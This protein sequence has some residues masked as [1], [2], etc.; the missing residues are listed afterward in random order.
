[1]KNREREEVCILRISHEGQGGKTVRA[2]AWID[3]IASTR[4]GDPVT[5]VL[6]AKKRERET[7]SLR[8]EKEKTVLGHGVSDAMVHALLN[9]IQRF[10]HPTL[11]FPGGRISAQSQVI[12]VVPWI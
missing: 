4:Y 8:R 10:R 3:G 9:L 5:R 1:M 7:I 2:H 6:H 11:V 12:D